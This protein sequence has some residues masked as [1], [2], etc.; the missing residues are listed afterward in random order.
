MTKM[1]IDQATILIDNLHEKL[2]GV[3]ADPRFYMAS[4]MVYLLAAKM[5]DYL[6]LYKKGSMQDGNARPYVVY[7]NW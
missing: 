1:P 5:T 6:G 2:I 4:Y 7:P 3:Q